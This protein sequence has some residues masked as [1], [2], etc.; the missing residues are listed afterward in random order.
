MKSWYQKN[1]GVFLLAVCMLFLFVTLS[2]CSS[3]MDSSQSGFW[4]SK[5]DRSIISQED[6]RKFVAG[7]RPYLRSPQAHFRQ[8]VLH[9][10]RHQHELAIEEFNKVLRQDPEHIKALNARGVSSDT[11]GDYETALKSYRTALSLDPELD[12]VYN[13][14]GYSYFL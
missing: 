8:G 13:N 14:L 12:F 7:V 1:A 5:Q 10:S 6:I 3:R 11:L 9:Q 2:A 4:G